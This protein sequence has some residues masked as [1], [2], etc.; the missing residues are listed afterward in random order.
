MM[1]P[2]PYVSD[3][4]FVDERTLI[5]CGDNDWISVWDCAA[6]QQSLMVKCES[7]FKTL[8]FSKTASLVAVGNSNGTIELFGWPKFE[9]R[10]AVMAHPNTP[11]NQL[12][13][14]RDGRRLIS[15]CTGTTITDRKR[16]GEIAVWAL[17]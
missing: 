4:V 7:G 5:S 6:G 1:A 16:D 11:I 9:R 3:L 15:A 8:A 17:P 14:T 13:F 12:S 2:I 10:G